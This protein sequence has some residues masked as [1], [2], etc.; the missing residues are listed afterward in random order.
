MHRSSRVDTS[1]A[2]PGAIITEALLRQPPPELIHLLT[3]GRDQPEM[4]VARDGSVVSSLR[5]RKILPFEEVATPIG[6]A[7][8]EQGERG[9]VEAPRLLDV[10]DPNGDVVE[11]SG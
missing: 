7:E 5:D 6:L 2:A 4:R 11:H 10:G 3:R 9:S 1:R 8:A